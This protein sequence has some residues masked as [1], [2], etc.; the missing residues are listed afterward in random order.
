M[1]DR[2]LGSKE[3]AYN[4]RESFLYLGN[5]YPIQISHDINIKQDHVVFEGNKLHIYV[6]QLEDKKIKQALNDFIISSVKR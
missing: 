4:H 3:K 2:M 6:K 1:K 5:T